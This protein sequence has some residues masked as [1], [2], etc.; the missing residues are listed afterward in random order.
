MG[1]THP[2]LTA[3]DHPP[4]GQT[5]IP[6]MD[7]IDMSEDRGNLGKNAN[8]FFHPSRQTCSARWFTVRD[9]NGCQNR[10]TTPTERRSI[11][12]IRVKTCHFQVTPEIDRAL[13]VK[14]FLVLGVTPI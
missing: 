7:P 5:R 3:S 12:G 11:W 13:T 1:C 9:W 8:S 10:R 4:T 14:E 6:Q 2:A